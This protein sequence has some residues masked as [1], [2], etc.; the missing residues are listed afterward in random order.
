MHI[1]I[2]KYYSVK[3]KYS[4]Q[5]QLVQ[6]PKTAFGFVKGYLNDQGIHKRGAE[7]DRLVKVVQV[8]NVQLDNTLVVL[9]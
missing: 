4:V 2:Q 7:V 8:L 5:E 9:S 3:I 6:L 1:T